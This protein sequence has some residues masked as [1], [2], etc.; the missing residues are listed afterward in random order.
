MNRQ[1]TYDKV[2]DHLMTQ[3]KPSQ[4]YSHSSEMMMCRY[5]GSKGRMCAIGCLIPDEL[6]S[7]SIEGEIVR[8]LPADILAALGVSG[9]DDA[10]FLQRLQSIHDDVKPSF[11]AESLYEFAESNGLRP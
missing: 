8:K 9:P 11:W 5:R 10:H 7:S 3:R 1:E 6:Y 2:R 4:K